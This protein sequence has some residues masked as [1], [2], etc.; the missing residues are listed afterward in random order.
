MYVGLTDCENET[1]EYY[2]QSFIATAMAASIG[3]STI[4]ISF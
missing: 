4:S 3:F 1:K 2:C